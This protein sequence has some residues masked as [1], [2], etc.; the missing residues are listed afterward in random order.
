MIARDNGKTPAINT[1]VRSVQKRQARTY[2]EYRERLQS[3][4]DSLRSSTG[5]TTETVEEPTLEHFIA[6]DTTVEALGD[7]FENNP[8]G[9]LIHRDELAG[10]I[11]GLNQYKGG[12]GNDRQHYLEILQ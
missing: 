1:L 8:R 10:W 2:K 6:S 7:I 4:K 11:L 9:I 12:A 5:E 3:Y